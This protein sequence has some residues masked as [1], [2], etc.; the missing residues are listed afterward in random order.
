MA[1]VIDDEDPLARGGPAGVVLGRAQED[2][3]LG[4]HRNG[5]RAEAEGPVAPVAAHEVGDE[6]VRRLDEQ[7]GRG[8][9]LRDHAADLQD[10]D[11][12]PEFD[13]LIDV[14]GDKDDRLAEIGLQ[15][16]EL[17]LQLLPDDRVDGAEGLIHEHDRRVRGQGPRHAH[18]LLLTA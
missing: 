12:V 17:V 18:P 2:R 11:L 15:P 4:R 16:Q 3:R 10:D 9:H 7:G 6:V 14:V 13:G 5:G 8:R 1:L